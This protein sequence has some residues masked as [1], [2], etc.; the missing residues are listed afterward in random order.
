LV[1]G[2]TGLTIDRVTTGEHPPCPGCGYDLHGLTEVG[3]CP[4]CG[5]PYDLRHRA[6]TQLHRLLR[7]R[8]WLDRMDV[9]ITTTLVVIGVGLLIALVYAVLVG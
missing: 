1:G 9:V 4:E 3:C 6:I 2:P 8:R 7:R 5:R